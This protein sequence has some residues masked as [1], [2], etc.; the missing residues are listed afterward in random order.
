MVYVC[1]VVG[2]DLDA[3][4]DM[5][6]VHGGFTGASPLSLFFDV[7]S[8]Y[9]RLVALASLFQ[10]CHHLSRLTLLPPVLTIRVPKMVTFW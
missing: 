4:L 7:F 8:R 1:V 9:H 10:S 5:H 3:V 2:V 6:T